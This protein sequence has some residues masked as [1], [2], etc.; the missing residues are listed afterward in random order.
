[1][2]IQAVLPSLVGGRTANQTR[3]DQSFAVLAP[4]LWNALP[5][6]LTTIESAAKFK[7][8]LTKFLE[9]LDDTPPTSGYM[10]NHDNSLPE[11]LRR[12][13]FDERSSLL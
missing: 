5:S 7:N 2:G 1:M 8:D 6:K 13:G 12:L 10:R 11:V 9:N 4:K 3:Y